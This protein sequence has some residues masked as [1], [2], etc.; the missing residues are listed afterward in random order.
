MPLPVLSFILKY[1]VTPKFGWF[2]KSEWFA[3]KFDDWEGLYTDAMMG[4]EYRFFKNVGL[5]AGLGSNSLDISEN[6][7]DHKFNFD[8]RM[9]GVFIYAATY[10]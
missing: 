3:L 4:I 6:T 9:T 2:V 5:G 7:S 8:N 10:F 1:K